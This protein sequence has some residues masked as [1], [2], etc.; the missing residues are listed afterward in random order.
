MSSAARLAA[1]R[2]N[3][4]AST[5]PRTEQGK[6]RSS[7]N[8]ASLGLFSARAFVRPEE[9]AEY[10]ALR[11]GLIAELAP[12]SLMEQA[13][14]TEILNSMWRLRRCSLVEASLADLDAAPDTL[15]TQ[16]AI[17]R[18][19][20]HAGNTLRRSTT[21]LRRLQT[22]RQLLSGLGPTQGLASHKE[23]STT[24]VADAQRN[25]MLGKLNGLDT[26]E[27]LLH[28]AEA[29]DDTQAGTNQRPD[30]VAN[31]TAPKTETAITKRSHLQPADSPDPPAPNLPPPFL[32]PPDPPFLTTHAH[33]RKAQ[34]SA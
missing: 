8:A 3:A 32:K 19:R 27:S 12:A 23:A 7:Q 31:P 4:Q 1:N 18:D 29:L 15:P 30:P 13:H 16:N 34:H 25:L 11:A 10:D 6:A 21:E 14:A 17:D 28:A 5:G 20:A 9:I 2:Q 26:L 33:L 22:E 24:L